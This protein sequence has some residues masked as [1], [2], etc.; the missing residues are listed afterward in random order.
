[1][2]A[3]ANTQD[4]LSR[5]GLRDCP[6]GGNVTR[7]LLGY[8]ALAGPFSRRRDLF[9]AAFTGRDRRGAVRSTSAS[10]LRS[11]PATPG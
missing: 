3:I 1:M 11:S 8:L 6:A 7:S 10:R 5:P 2:T 9:D 4:T